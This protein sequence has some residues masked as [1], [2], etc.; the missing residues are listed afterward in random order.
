MSEKQNAIIE[1]VNFPHDNA[2]EHEQQ[3][4]RSW[5]M[6]TAHLLPWEHH[7]VRELIEEDALC[8]LAAGLGWQRIAAVFIRLHHY[9]K[10]RTSVL[11]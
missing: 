8:V 1:S 4:A 9:Q 3:A 11:H 6:S 7:L 5:E 10:V 2:E